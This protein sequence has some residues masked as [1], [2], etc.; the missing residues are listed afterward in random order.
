MFLLIHECML[1]ANEYQIL[2]CILK[3]GRRII[4]FTV[5]KQLV[6]CQGNLFANQQKT[7]APFHLHDG[8]R[9]HPLLLTN[10]GSKNILESGVVGLITGIIKNKSPKPNALFIYVSCRYPCLLSARITMGS[11]L[12]LVIALGSPS[13]FVSYFLYSNYWQNFTNS[14]VFGSV[15]LILHCLELI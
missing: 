13:L 11:E 14:E 8:K 15:M 4:F 10:K 5:G 7:A 2:Q 12:L 9:S 1:D 6:S 3:E